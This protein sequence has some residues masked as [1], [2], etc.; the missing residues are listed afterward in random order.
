MCDVDRNAHVGK[1]EAIAQEDQSQRNYVVH[2]K[3][4]KVLPWLLQ[5]QHQDDGLLGPVAGLQQV[6]RLEDG[7]MLPMRKAFEHGSGVKIPDIR[8]LHDIQPIRTKDTKVNRCVDLLHEPR[9][10]GLAL[11]S[12]VFPPRPN[13]APHEKLACEREHDGV[14][15][16]ERKILGTLAVHHRSP[17]GLRFLSVGEEDGVVQRVRLGGVHRVG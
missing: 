6:V 3:F 12:A 5:L 7:H 17:G 9:H 8:L 14:E 4:F 1:V 13:D 2:H 10:L 16:H 11:D 15:S